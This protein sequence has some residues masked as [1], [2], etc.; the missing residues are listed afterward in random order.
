MVRT[1]YA[2]LKAR[3]A[4]AE[5]AKEY[6]TELSKKLLYRLKKSKERQ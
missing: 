5:V 2:V 3:N 6:L 4:A 1:L